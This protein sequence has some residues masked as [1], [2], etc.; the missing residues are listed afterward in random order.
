MGTVVGG[1]V[2]SIVDDRTGGLVGVTV[3]TKV[4]RSVAAPVESSVDGMVVG[5]TEDELAGD[6]EGK[7]GKK[8]G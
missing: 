7:S 6:T 3:M 1:S 4:G 5:N 8:G 2:A